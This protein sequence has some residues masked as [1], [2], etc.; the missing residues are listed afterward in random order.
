[1]Q[2]RTFGTAPKF[3][4]LQSFAV[5]MQTGTRGDII[6]AFMK[7]KASPLFASKG[8]QNA[9]TKFESVFDGETPFSVFAE[10]NSKLP[11]SALS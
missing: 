2:T 10:G 9:M 1:M 5:T 6:R 8:W 11:F 4:A 7:L 3:E